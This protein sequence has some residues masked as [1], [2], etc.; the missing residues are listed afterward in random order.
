MVA[1]V[2]GTPCI[3]VHV[4]PIVHRVPRDPRQ[5]GEGPSFLAV[6]V[7]SGVVLVVFFLIA[8]F[9]LRTS[10]QELL[11]GV[12]QTAH[13]HSALRLEQPSRAV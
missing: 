6:V 12:H 13:P 5:R 3:Q 1:N 2:S 7:M 10:G 4:E 8:Y 9:V 11:P